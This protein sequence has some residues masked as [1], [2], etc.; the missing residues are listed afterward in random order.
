MKV[1]QQNHEM[2]ETYKVRAVI[3]KDEDKEESISETVVAGNVAS[4]YTVAIAKAQDGGNRTPEVSGINKLYDNKGKV[5][6][7]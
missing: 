2:L 3:K 6:H 1:E 5:S 7:Q 4:A